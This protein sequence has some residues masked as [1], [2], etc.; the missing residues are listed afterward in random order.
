MSHESDER[1]ERNHKFN[2]RITITT[3]GD[4]SGNRSGIA[5]KKKR[6]RLDL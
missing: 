4:T 3:T 5:L 1:A 6:L 2:S